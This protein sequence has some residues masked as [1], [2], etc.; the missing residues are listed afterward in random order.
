[1]HKGQTELT[2]LPYVYFSTVYCT[3]YFLNSCSSESFI[4]DKVEPSVKITYNNNDK[5]YSITCL[6]RPHTVL[7]FN[8]KRTFGVWITP[9]I[10]YHLFFWSILQS[11]ISIIFSHDMEEIDLL[12]SEDT[13]IESNGSS[14]SIRIKMFKLWR[15]LRSI[16]T[17]SLFFSWAQKWADAERDRWTAESPSAMNGKCDIMRDIDVCLCCVRRGLLMLKWPTLKS[18]LVPLWVTGEW[19][20]KDWIRHA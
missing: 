16:S 19:Q 15:L 3:V 10:F 14:L 7:T 18:Y 1:M 5:T 4:K 12:L 2:T 11:D 8:S 13:F 17:V 9:V 6:T 20:R